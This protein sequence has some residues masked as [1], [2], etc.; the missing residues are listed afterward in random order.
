V[1]KDAARQVIP[2]EVIDRPKGYFPVP[3]LKYI[4]GPYLE[5]A[6]AALESP[7]ARERGLFRRD[8]LD[9]LFAAPADHIT[10]LRGSEL[11]QVAAL[12][13]WLQARG[14]ERWQTSRAEPRPSIACAGCVRAAQAGRSG[15]APRRGRTPRSTAAGAG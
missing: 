1:L 7:A 14:S 15:P 5:M 13:M 11:W 3:A 6:R 8:W 10:R 9:D 4:D 12:E 2:S